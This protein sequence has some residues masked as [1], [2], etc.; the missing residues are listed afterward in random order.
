MPLDTITVPAN[1][2]PLP[3][4]ALE[5]IRDADHRIERFMNNH[6]AAPIPAFV[7]SDHALVYQVLQSIRD[8]RLAPGD[9]FCEWGAGFAVAASLAASLGYEAWAIEIES[10][11]VR[12]AEDLAE[13]HDQSVEVLHGSIIPRSGQDAIDDGGELIALRTEGVDP[14]ED[15]GMGIEDFDVIFAFP[16]PGEHEVFER[17]F[18][19]HAATGALL[20]MYHGLD[21]VRVSRRQ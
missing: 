4:F 17:L 3:E 18:E 5:L 7:P 2:M 11:L 16:W 14:L 12:E 6:R 15:H 19:T 21:G 20:V 8:H 10:D 1:E 9:C 13:T